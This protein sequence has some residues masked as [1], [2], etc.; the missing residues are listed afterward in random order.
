MRAVE[1]SIARAIESYRAGD[2]PAMEAACHIVLAAD[3]ENPDALQMMAV[4]ERKRGNYERAIGHLRIVARAHP[5][6]AQVHLLLGQC[7]E[8]TGRVA[9]ANESFERAVDLDPANSVI[10]EMYAQTLQQRWSKLLN[11]RL[12]GREAIKTYAAKLQSGFIQKYLS[13]PHVLDIGYRG[14]SHAA[15]TIVPQAIGVDLDYP[16]YDGIRLPFPD[17]SQDAVFSSHCL[18]HMP[19]PVAALR[20]WHRVLRVGGHVVAMVPHQHLYEK[21][22]ELPSRFNGGHR[23]FFTPAKL[24]TMLEEALPPNAYR[25]RH[26]CDNDFLYDYAV[27]PEQHPVWCYEIELVVERIAQPSWTIS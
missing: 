3:G 19:D 23:H 11:L 24:L 14:H 6:L 1:G 21:K 22:K 10:R 2:Y 12:V 7:L 5:G 18:E 13:G 15:E 17:L 16:G 20:E 9:E 26:L 27:P 8:A 4:L 25:V